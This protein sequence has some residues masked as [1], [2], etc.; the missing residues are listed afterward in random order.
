VSTTIIFVGV[1]VFGFLVARILARISPDRIGL[2]DVE[3]LV[4]GA[5]LGPVTA[6]RL[7]T[8]EV[9]AALD[10]FVS[11]LLGLIGFL[12]GLG[13]RRAFRDFEVGMAGVA[14]SLLV[15][16]TVAAAASAAVQASHPE[17]LDATDPVLSVPLLAGDSR[18]LSLWLAPEALWVGLALAAAAGASSATT[19]ARVAA[20]NN[21]TGAR[22]TL[23]EGLATAGHAT[24]VV[25]LGI[26]MAGSRATA[27][28]GELGLTLIEW[29]VIVVGFG[30]ASGLL[31]SVYLGRERDSMRMTVAAVGAVTFAAGAGAALRVSPLFVNLAA[32]AMVALSSGHAEKLEEALSP[33]AYPVSVLVL[34]FAGAYWLPV[35]GWLWLLPIGYAVIRWCARRVFTRL[36]VATFVHEPGLERGIGRGLYAHGVIAAAVALGFVQR[37][38][39]YADV[40][41]T[42]VLGGMLLT[43]L[44]APR[45]LRRFF[46]DSGEIR[47][48]EE[49]K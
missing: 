35:H 9:L 27:S 46:A 49:G 11:I 10:L 12:A 41:L 22:V 8:P 44:L 48:A 34:L 45:A 19:I 42:T 15:I 30:A 40:V 5:V 6:P 31:F 36:A 4:L 1:L 18:L 39:D 29:G 47:P 33:L 2:T 13:L 28:A 43:N 20:K 21:V 14:S 7:L 38:R 23:L 25:V 26:A 16:L 24:A 37:F 32:G 3:F 17:L